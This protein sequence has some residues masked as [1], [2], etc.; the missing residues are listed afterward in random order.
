MTIPAHLF[1]PARPLTG[2]DAKTLALAALG[3]ALEFYDFVI[4]VF[5]TAV[6]GKLFFPPDMP[7]W[8]GQLQTF[9][10][11][12]A[13]Y[14]FRPLGG[15]V[16][17]HFGDTFGR[18]RMFTLS[19]AL[20]AV[21]TLLIGLLP[22]Y[23]SIGYGA[24]L[25]LLLMRIM[26]GIA[27]GGEVPGAW[28]FVSEHVP[29]RRVGLACALLETGLTAGILLGSLV[30]TS[31]NKSL[32]PEAV[33]DWGW[34]VPFLLGGGF[35][36]VIVYL[37]RWL[38]ETP[39]F[40]EIRALKQI[41]RMPIRDVIR[42][43]KPDVVVSVIAAWMLTA[44]MVVIMLMTPTLLVKL[45]G[46]P[47]VA[48]LQANTAATLGLCVSVVI[49]GMACDRW[50]AAWVAAVATPLL[51][52]AIYAL[53]IGVAR[54]PALLLPLYGLAGFFAGVIGIV[55]IVMIRSF[56]AAVRF[57]GLSLCYNLAYAAVGG[58]TPVIIPALAQVT[59]LA[60]AHYVTLACVVGGA[61]IL[62]Q[63]RRR[64]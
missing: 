53:Y 36:L 32:S 4:F 31:I 6:L 2:Q 25:L 42:D 24:P 8:L 51:I 5:F 45:H 33:H 43:Y 26:Q 11:F 50:G 40:E 9:G 55:P 12:A 56:P 52:A 3:G 61:A 23:Q 22:T 60:P 57:T 1:V 18:K 10:I 28:V 20:M 49:A 35:G 46:V 27:I 58:L 47:L 62:L 29:Y 15:I 17:A 37:R 41:S 34:R 16:M 14:L 7:E 19:V 39:V 38:Q 13:G 64:R 44:C 59:P 54:D 21:P 48:A 30:A 63:A